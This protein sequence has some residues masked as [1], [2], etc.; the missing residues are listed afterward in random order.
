MKEYIKVNY[1]F[2]TTLY[3]I[4]K[5]LKKL[6][7]YDILSLDFEAQ[8]VYSLKERAEAKDLLK[9]YSEDMSPDDIR[10]SKM[11]ARSSGLSNPRI[12]KVTHVI[13]GLSNHESVVLVVNGYKS[14][15]AIMDWIVNYPGKLIIHNSLFDLKI[16]HYWTNK[17]P[18]DFI[19]TQL[20][21]KTVINHTENW[22]AKSGLKDLM[23]GHYD[24]RWCE[25]ESYDIQD[26]KN[27]AFLRY[28][29]IDGAATYKLYEELQEHLNENT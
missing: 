17:L 29:A 25:I 18:K 11:V 9:Q 26:F 22:K 28:S 13:F 15:K 20:L 21:T 2:H 1:E 19:D 7:S 12:S 14:L 4:N 3:S 16:V 27:E 24:P 5:A 8:S 6:E 23:S 10:L